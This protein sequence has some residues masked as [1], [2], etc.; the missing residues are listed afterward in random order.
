MPRDAGRGRRGRAPPADA[1]LFQVPWHPA[2]VAH[3]RGKARLRVTPIEFGDDGNE[4]WVRSHPD[5]AGAEFARHRKGLLGFLIEV[6]ESTGHAVQAGAELG[7][8]DGPVDA[9]DQTYAAALFLR[10]HPTR[11]GGLG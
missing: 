9:V 7:E 11:K 4:R 8:D 10:L 6:L 3:I 2:G 5:A 1:R